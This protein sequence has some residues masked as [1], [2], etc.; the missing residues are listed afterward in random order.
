MTQARNPPKLTPSS[1]IPLSAPGGGE[2]WGEVG[3]IPRPP[4]PTSP[5]HPHP[6]LPRKRARVREG[7]GPSLFPLKGGEGNVTHLSER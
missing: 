6:P 5:F 7:A 1:K 3:E 4:A 2:G